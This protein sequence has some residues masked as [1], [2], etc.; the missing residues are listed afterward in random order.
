MSRIP[1]AEII[2]TTEMIGTVCCLRACFRTTT[3]VMPYLPVGLLQLETWRRGLDV[4]TVAIVEYN[5][6]RMP[7]VVATGVDGIA[8]ISAITKA[9]DPVAGQRGSCWR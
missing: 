2:D 9:K 8:M 6:G 1:G 4:R 7:G 5:L 3:K